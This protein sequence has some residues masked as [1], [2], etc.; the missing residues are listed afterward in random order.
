MN[1][2]VTGGEEEKARC[3][4]VMDNPRASIHSQMIVEQ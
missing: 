1:N 2:S 3:N 4:S